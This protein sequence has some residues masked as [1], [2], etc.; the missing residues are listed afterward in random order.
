MSF[1]SEGTLTLL[2]DEGVAYTYKVETFGNRLILIS[3]K[4]QWTYVSDKTPI[5]VDKVQNE[6]DE[7]KDQLK[8]KQELLKLLQEKEVI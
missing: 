5:L 4:G 7:L 8:D 2:N 6:I 1:H 3:D